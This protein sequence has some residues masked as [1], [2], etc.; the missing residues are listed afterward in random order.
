MDLILRNAK[1]R[2]GETV[3]IG[4]EK[5]LI[6]AMDKSLDLKAKTEIDVSGKLVSSAF[7]DPHIHLDKVNILD[8]VRPNKSGTLK[9]AIEIIWEKKQS[10]TVED[11]VER[12]SEV[13]EKAI[14]NGT[15]LCEPM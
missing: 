8:V 15:L 12:A 14:Q 9:E 4:I 3:D 13:V 7:I 2:T 1:L 5:G 11:V 10:Y 6:E